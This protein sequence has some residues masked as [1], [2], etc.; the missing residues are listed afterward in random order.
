MKKNLKTI[1]SLAMTG[2]TALLLSCNTQATD[3]EK[4]ID[5]L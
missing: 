2:L 4:Q 5:E 3:M 1:G